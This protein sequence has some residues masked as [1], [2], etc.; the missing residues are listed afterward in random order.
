MWRSNGIEIMSSNR[1]LPKSG[2]ARFAGDPPYYCLSRWEGDSNIIVATEGLRRASRVSTMS[3]F[4][5]MPGVW[6]PNRARIT[7]D[8]RDYLSH[9]FFTDTQLSRCFRPTTPSELMKTPPQT[10][11]HDA[12]WEICIPGKK[13]LIST[14][15]GCSLALQFVDFERG[16]LMTLGHVTL[17]S[18]LWVALF[19][20]AKT[21]S[22]DHSLVGVFPYLHARQS[23]FRYP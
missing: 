9:L 8:R 13:C 7:S 19:G 21:V 4:P 1:R 2:V 17:H 22:T 23:S 5:S 20:E 16:P 18:L 3:G 12:K 10:M 11:S 14:S 15:W 6:G